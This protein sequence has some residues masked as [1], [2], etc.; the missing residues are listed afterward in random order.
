M[1]NS[2]KYLGVLFCEHGDS[3]DVVPKKWV[4]NWGEEKECRYPE[5]GAELAGRRNAV[6]RSFLAYLQN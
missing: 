5:E 4:S 6:A 3:N 2:K 1:D